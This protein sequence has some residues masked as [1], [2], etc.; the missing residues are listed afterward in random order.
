MTKLRQLVTPDCVILQLN[1]VEPEQVVLEMIQHLA[2]TGKISSGECY[3]CGNSVLERE[4]HCGTGVGSGVAIPHGRVAGLKETLAVFGRSV[5]G[6]DFE[7]P[8]NAPSH[9]VCLLLVPEENNSQHLQTLAELAK[10]FSQ[11]ELRDRLEQAQSAEEF[12]Q[13]LSQ[14]SS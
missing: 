7:S 6:V 9:L 8:D 3:R 13:F 1:E 5:E 12:C 14:A 2:K 4:S 11:S 10:L